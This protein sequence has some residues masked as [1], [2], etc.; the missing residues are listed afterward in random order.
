[1]ERRFIVALFLCVTVFMAFNMYNL[2][3][4]QKFLQENPEYLE[5]LKEQQRRA[6]AERD[7]DSATGEMDISPDGGSVSRPVLR[8]ATAP[9]EMFP[10][11]S[12]DEAEPADEML[13]A[14]TTAV[15]TPS[16]KTFIVR[17]PLY[18][19]EIAAQGGRL[20]SWKLLQYQEILDKVYLLE[21]YREK[22]QDD[23]PPL[24]RFLERKIEWI[25]QKRQLEEQI[26][27]EPDETGAWPADFA[28][29]MVP[30]LR[31]GTPPLN[32]QWGRSSLDDLVE[33]QANVEV[34]DVTGES[35]LVLTG[36]V[37]PFQ[38][39]KKFVFQED[40]YSID[41]SISITNISDKTIDFPSND[42][43]SKRTMRL[44]W[45]NGVGLDIFNDYLAPPVLFQVGNKILKEYDIFKRQ[46][47]QE[48]TALDWAMIQNKYFTSVLIPEGPVRPRVKNERNTYD[49]GDLDLALNLGQLEPGQTRQEPFELYVGPKDPDKLKE[50][51][52]GAF[53]SLFLGFFRSMAKPFALFFLW[54]LRVIHAGVG[55]WG[56][57]IIV[58]T[59]LTKAA[60]YPLTRKQ[61]QSML[62]MKKIQPK[63]KALE[64]YKSNQQKYQ[65]EV[66]ELYK[67]E[68]INPMG[69]CLPMLLTM[70]IF[71]ALY[72]VIY[73]T[74]ELR[75]A[76]FVLWI[77]DLSQPDTL[78]SFYIPAF[79]YVFRF[80]VLP[81]LNGLQ[82]WFSMRKQNLDPNQAVIT[83]IMPIMITVLFW[84]F[85]S[86]LL[87]YWLVQGLLS[88]LQ[89][90][91]FN[92]LH[93]DDLEKTKASA[94]AGN[95]PRT[96]VRAKK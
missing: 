52:Y 85:P 7:P 3:Q 90:Q 61:M 15:L 9:E 81:I 31:Q 33:Y 8:D 69:G 25:R 1:M 91:L 30:V 22:F 50:L 5:K 70:P 43:Y 32:L 19:V 94:K 65:K 17:S 67:R 56:L 48:N 74:P 49:H 14:A 86:G 26:Q 16:D 57:A 37:G 87:L 42:I 62:K 27:P 92:Y 39:T 29:E 20:V 21:D 80:N 78:F 46:R 24:A 68:K 63:I 4:E 47:N 40:D 2:W 55:N 76:P 88:S 59:V 64:K 13:L 77:K 44:T 84:S 51:G 35:P 11:L 54:F 60:M 93:A 41:Y 10:S 96:A 71:I 72:V 12:A 95:S 58:M 82:M 73:I 6:A 45:D 36:N 28:V 23:Y 66:M 38:I 34:L 18:R 53:D 89:Q 75:G 79:S 83:Q